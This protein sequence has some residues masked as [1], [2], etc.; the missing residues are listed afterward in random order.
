M[1]K[2]S[3]RNPSNAKQLS[4]PFKPTILKILRNE[5]GKIW[6]HVRQ[7]WYIETPEGRVR[8]E[9]LCVLGSMSWSVT[10]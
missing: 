9:F 10:A 2:R 7:N 8:Q 5:Q 6:S 3:L 4:E 1:K